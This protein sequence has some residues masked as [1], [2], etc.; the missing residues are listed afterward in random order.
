MQ[1]MTAALQVLQE[2]IEAHC[3]R[4]RSAAPD[5]LCRRGCERCCRTLKGAPRLTRV[6]WIWVEDALQQLP[7]EV[8]AGVAAR[9]ALLGEGTVVCPFLDGN[10]GACLIY[11]ARP[12]PCRTYGFY[13]ERELGQYCG[14]ILAEVEAGRRDSVVWG[15]AAAVERDRAK[16]GDLIGLQKWWAELSER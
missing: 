5:W 12:I 3:A 15:N 13:V 2:E 7:E 4:I 8:K 9:I 11:D 14:M 10:A 16:L 6:E 1:Q